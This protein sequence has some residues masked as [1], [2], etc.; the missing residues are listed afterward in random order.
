MIVPKEPLFIIC[1][2]LY[3][4]KIIRLPVRL[5][6][7]TAKEYLR[8]AGAAMGN[9][10]INGIVMRPKIIPALLHLVFIRKLLLPPCQMI[11]AI[12]LISFIKLFLLLLEVRIICL[13]D[14]PTLQF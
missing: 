13:Q 4:L 10:V 3:K 7:R 2:V 11:D 8:T 9:N 14:P 6:H 12:R 5:I 1:I